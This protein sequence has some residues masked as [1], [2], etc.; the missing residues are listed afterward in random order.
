MVWQMI[1]SKVNFLSK[2]FRRAY[3][4]L[5]YKMSGKIKGKDLSSADS[6]IKTAFYQSPTSPKKYVLL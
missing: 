5:F 6:L 2:N 3:G 4:D 1:R